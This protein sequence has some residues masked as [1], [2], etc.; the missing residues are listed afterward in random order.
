MALS[1]EE[2]AC[3]REMLRTFYGS[4]FAPH[5]PTE[6]TLEYVEQIL[7]EA[8]KCEKRIDK[9]L[10]SLLCAVVGRGF[11]RRCLRAAARVVSD[12]AI[13]FSGCGARAALNFKT[14]IQLSLH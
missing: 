10:A 2:Q 9:L 14:A 1:P 3:V 5:T 13:A 4:D 8:Q 7:L 6:E 12:N 11:L